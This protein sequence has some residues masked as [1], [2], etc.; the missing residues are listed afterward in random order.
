MDCTRTVTPA[1]ARRLQDILRELPDSATLCFEGR[2]EADLHIERSVTLR[3]RGAVV[4]DGRRRATVL[5]IPTA[6]ITLAVENL[7]LRRGAGGALGE[8]G[9]VS[10]LKRSTVTLRDVVLEHGEADANG[11]GAILALDGETVRPARQPRG[12]R[13]GRARRRDRSRRDA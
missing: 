8:G 13:A 4:I 12:A 7:T 5:T 2:Y 1:D 3:G 9:C 10:V 11:G 6:G